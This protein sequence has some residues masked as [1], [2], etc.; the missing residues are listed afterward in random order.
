MK[1]RLEKGLVVDAYHLCWDAE[2]SVDA[3][4]LADWQTFKRNYQEQRS[5]LAQGLLGRLRDSLPLAARRAHWPKGRRIPFALGWRRFLPPPLAQVL[6][7]GKVLWPFPQREVLFVISTLRRLLDFA[8]RPAKPAMEEI[9][10]L[11]QDLYACELVIRV[12]CWGLAELEQMPAEYP[13][14]RLAG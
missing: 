2:R 11:R 4:L 7:R 12:R 13:S 1:I 9:V 8:E 14:T 6:A 3:L 10:G 5:P